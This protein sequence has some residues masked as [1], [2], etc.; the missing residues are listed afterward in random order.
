MLER[1][2][3]KIGSVYT[4]GGVIAKNPSPLGGTWAYCFVNQEGK[5]ICEGSGVLL[6]HEGDTLEVT[7]NQ[8]EYYAV[9]Q[10]LLALPDA[11]HGTL[12]SDSQITIGRVFRGWKCT[13]IPQPW[14]TG[15]AF[16]KK[17]LGRIRPVLLNG[18]P[19]PKHLEEGKGH[20]GRPVSLHNVHCDAL[21]TKTGLEYLHILKQP[22]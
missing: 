10:A 1:E 8:T 19:T 17:R 15:V 9:Y 21:C 18:H 2:G 5:R 6:P 13:N 14:I 4:D 7:N 11:W 22:T 20:G 12:F 16:E 3:Y